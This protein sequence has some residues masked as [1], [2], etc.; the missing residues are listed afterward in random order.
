MTLASQIF[1]PRVYPPEVGPTIFRFLRVA[2]T[3]LAVLPTFT[4]RPFSTFSL[5]AEMAYLL[6]E[7]S[8]IKS[9]SIV[10]RFLTSILAVRRIYLT[11]EL[12]IAFISSSAVPTS[13]FSD[14]V[15][16][17]DSGTVTLVLPSAATTFSTFAFSLT[18][19]TAVA[20]STTSVLTVL[21]PLTSTFVSA[22]AS[23]GTT[24]SLTT[25]SG[26]ITT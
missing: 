2:L 6:L 16:P 5:E 22:E 3:A 4:V 1:N 12:D 13:V 24:T 15:A 18:S 23:V 26:S 10:I 25:A 9:R 19:T 20:L 14:F 8:M 17:T 11:E 7:P 21:F